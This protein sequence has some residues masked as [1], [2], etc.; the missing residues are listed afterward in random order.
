MCQQEK[1]CAHLRS[2]GIFDV[3]QCAPEMPVRLIDGGERQRAFEQRAAICQPPE[4]TTRQLQSQTALQS[5]TCMQLLT[6]A[7]T[8]RLRAPDSQQQ[9]EGRRASSRRRTGSPATARLARS[10]LTSAESRCS[11]TAGK[12]PRSDSCR[13]TLTPR[14]GGGKKRKGA[15]YYFGN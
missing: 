15:F 14:H 7:A 10:F 12:S 11:S 2:H 13:G 4:L 9:R 8:L 1:V 6:S 5:R 3:E